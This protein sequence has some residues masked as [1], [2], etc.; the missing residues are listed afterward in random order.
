MRECC[1]TRP[2]KAPEK[3]ARRFILRDAFFEEGLAFVGRTTKPTPVEK[4]R[5]LD[6]AP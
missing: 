6:A 1:T 2:K 3:R 5:K 4:R